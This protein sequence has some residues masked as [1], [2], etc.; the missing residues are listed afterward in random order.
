[1]TIAVRYRLETQSTS[2]KKEGLYLSASSKANI[3]GIC[4]PIPPSLKTLRGYSEPVLCIIYKRGDKVT[5][6]Y[7]SNDQSVDI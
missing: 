2:Q 7:F 1:M 3:V 4:N 6:D 5:I